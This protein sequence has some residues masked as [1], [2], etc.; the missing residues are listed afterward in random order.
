MDVNRAK[1]RPSNSRN[2]RKMIVAGGL[3]LKLKLKIKN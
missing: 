3:K 2:S 1:R